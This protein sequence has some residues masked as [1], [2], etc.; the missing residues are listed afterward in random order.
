MTSVIGRPRYVLN[1]RSATEEKKCIPSL[2]RISYA[3]T[4]VIAIQE[5]E[6]LLILWLH[7]ARLVKCSLATSFFCSR[8]FFYMHPLVLV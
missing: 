6:L 7:I 2:E 4:G 5:K 1:I 8:F 3:T